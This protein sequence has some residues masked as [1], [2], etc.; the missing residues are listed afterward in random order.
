MIPCVSG[1]CILSACTVRRFF[2]LSAVAVERVRWM[3]SSFGGV[4]FVVTDISSLSR[5]FRRRGNGRGLLLDRL[6]QSGV[7]DL[8]LPVRV[9]E[10]AAFL[11]PPTTRF[12]IRLRVRDALQLRF[13]LAADV[14][15]VL[16]A[17]L[18]LTAGRRRDEV[19]W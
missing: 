13:L 7:A 15:P 4:M 17:R 16:A 19:R 14:A 12:V 10:P 6:D 11:R 18:E 5:R 3:N 9:D 8:A 1:K 2:P